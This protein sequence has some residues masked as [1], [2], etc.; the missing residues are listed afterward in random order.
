[1]YIY[2]GAFCLKSNNKH[3]RI[4]I[5]IMST[6]VRF[7]YNVQFTKKIIQYVFNVINCLL[8]SI[9]KYIQIGFTSLFNSLLYILAN[10]EL[11]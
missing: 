10:G 2:D 9:L 6:S 5:T 1:M 7:I 8:L 11:L 3:N 4:Y